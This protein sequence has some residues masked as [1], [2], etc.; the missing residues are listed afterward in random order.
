MTSTEKPQKPEWSAVYD[1]SC[2]RLFDGSV[3]VRIDDEEVA[4]FPPKREVSLDVL[5]RELRKICVAIDT[6]W[7][8]TSDPPEELGGDPDW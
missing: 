6:V 5:E 3:S 7:I 8:E 1:F 2:C 4:L